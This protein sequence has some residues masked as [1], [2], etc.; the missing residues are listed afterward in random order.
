MAEDFDVDLFGDPILSREETRG[1]PEHRWSL[2]NSN[3]VLL[4]FARGLDVKK[5][6]I[7]IGVSVPT[8]RKHY[9]AEVKKRDAAKLRMEMTQLAR[10]NKAAAEG[11]IAAEK[12]LGKRLD[13][14]TLA[15]TAERVANRGRNGAPPALPRLGKKEEATAKAEAVTGKYAPRPIPTRMMN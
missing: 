14:A 13:K 10:L 1:R 11:N 15:D 2:E 12:E 3:K 5:A 4:A 6:A 8:L 9:F 7:A